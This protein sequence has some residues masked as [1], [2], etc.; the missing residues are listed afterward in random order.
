MTPD[1]RLLK[2]S[3]FSTFVSVS[4]LLELVIPKIPTNQR[5][6]GTYMHMSLHTQILALTVLKSINN[7]LPLV[8][9]KNLLIVQNKI[10]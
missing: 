10:I 1:K 9:S 8:Q 3:P 7:L 6:H 4:Y 2:G 5:K